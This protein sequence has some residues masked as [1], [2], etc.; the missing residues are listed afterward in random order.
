M[1]LSENPAKE[2]VAK[3]LLTEEELSALVEPK[4]KDTPGQNPDKRRRIVPYDFRRPDRVSKE[5]V[6]SLYLLHDAFARNLSSTLPNFLR[7]ISE[8]TLMSLE[9]R[10]YV[11]YLSGLPDP[12]AIFKLGMKP[13][14]GTAVLEISPAIAFP[15]IDRQLGGQGESLSENR[16]LTDIEQEVLDAFLRIV[17][18]ALRAAWK[19]IVDINFQSV[20]RETCPKL[21]QIVAPHE[22]VLSIIFHVRVGDTRGTM[23]L[24]IPAINIEP[25]FQKLSE[26]AYSRMHPDVPPE[27]TRA[28]LNNLSS[29]L[30]P[31]AAEVRGAKASVRDLL[32]LSAGDVLRL[33]RRID[34]P[35]EVSVGGIVKFRGDL[36]A[37]EK[38]TA[39][40]IRPLIS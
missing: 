6:R 16:A 12:T 33:D 30:F 14:T 29:I 7:V 20:G 4:A 36:T 1:A 15:I 19:P 24:C 22:V 9:Q 25:I 13:L 21:L 40:H 11:E 35:V 32:R 38:R 34:E 3:P 27:Q 10:A 37:Y 26:S 31:L 39:V 8:V 18:D 28:V 23:S 2:P 5:Q 17:V